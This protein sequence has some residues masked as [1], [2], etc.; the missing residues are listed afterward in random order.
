MHILEIRF[1]VRLLSFLRYEVKVVR[2]NDT[3]RELTAEESTTPSISGTAPGERK[4]VEV[5]PETKV[6]P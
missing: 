4:K 1:L 3:K 6:S 5:T 2:T